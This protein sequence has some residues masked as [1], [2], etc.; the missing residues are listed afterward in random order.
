MPTDRLR[1][2]PGRSRNKA[3][4]IPADQD[5]EEL[6]TSRCGITAHVDQWYG[7]FTDAEIITAYKRPRCG[8]CLSY[9]RINEGREYVAPFYP[10]GKSA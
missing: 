4:L 2:L 3:H 5:G 8:T 9:Y 7:R 10:E 1:Y 6:R